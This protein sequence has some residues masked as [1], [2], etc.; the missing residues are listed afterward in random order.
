MATILEVSI[1]TTTLL[2]YIYRLGT[3]TELLANGHNSHIQREN[4][5]INKVLVVF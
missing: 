3:I 4:I 5:F 2:R 1:K